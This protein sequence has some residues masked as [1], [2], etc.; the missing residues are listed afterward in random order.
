MHWIIQCIGIYPV[1]ALVEL[2]TGETGIVIAQNPTMRLMPRVMAAL[3]SRKRPI[4][5][6]LVIDR[7]KIKRTLEKGSVPLD[8]S[9]FF[10]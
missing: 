10:I 4:K 1:G 3:D 6:P 5:P 8:P 9:E 2:Y 7:A